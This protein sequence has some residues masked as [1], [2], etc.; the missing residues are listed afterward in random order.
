MGRRREWCEWW[1]DECP[2]FEKFN[3]WADRFV[4]WKLGDRPSAEELRWAITACY[5]MFS[6]MAVSSPDPRFRKI[7]RDRCCRKSRIFRPNRPR[8]DLIDGGRP[9]LLCTF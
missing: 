1:P 7:A 6:C 9:L 3:H 5:C 2:C 8:G 4:E